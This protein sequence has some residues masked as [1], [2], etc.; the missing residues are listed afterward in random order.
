MCRDE[1]F[2]LKLLRD[3]W[4]VWW[5]LPLA[6]VLV[7]GGAWVHHVVVIGVERMMAIYFVVPLT[8][9]VLF[10]VLWSVMAAYR[11]RLVRMVTLM[12]HLAEDAS[13]VLVLRCPENFLFLSPRI[14]ALTGYDRDVFELT[15]S[16]FEQLIHEADKKAWADYQR[17]LWQG[18]TNKV[19][20]FTF[21]LVTTLRGVVW[22]EHESSC[23][24]FDGQRLC[25]CVLRDVSGEMHLKDAL[26]RL[27]EEDSLT[28]LSNRHVLLERCLAVEAP[29]VLTC[30]M[31]DIADLR[32]VNVRFGI[33]VGNFVLRTLAERLQKL[34]AVAQEE[35]PVVAISRLV[36]DNFVLVF[37]AERAQVEAWISEQMEALIQPVFSDKLRL[38]IELHLTFGYHEA[39][40]SAPMTRHQVEQML[41]AAYL[42]VHPL[43]IG[44]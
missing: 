11:A 31:V 32:Q 17:A 26:K 34:Q 6:V 27:A 25:R 21:R 10:G 3:S 29:T 14:R 12:R 30:V 28:G 23:F 5:R 38:F 41:R 18:E 33:E 20:T 37:Q 7:M 8:V 36:G 22:V 24:E 40:L 19:R 9:G 15:P 39:H 1:L 44:H 35:V 43:E 2:S 13:D 16:F 42:Q 4:R